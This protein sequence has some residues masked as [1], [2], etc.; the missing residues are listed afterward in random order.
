MLTHDPKLDDPA[1]K[2]ALPSA[3]FYVGALGSRT[4]QAR[5]RERLLAE[6]VSEAAL[7][8]LFGPI[9]LDLGAK[10]PEEIALSIMA[11]IV[12]ARNASGGAPD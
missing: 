10:T 2:L 11:E 7:G 1:L 6:G 4:T 12:S 5:R 8:R 3:A 9:G